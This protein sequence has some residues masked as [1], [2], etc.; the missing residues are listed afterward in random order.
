MGARRT[1]DHDE[2]DRG[3]SLR[4]NFA[5]VVYGVMS[6]MNASQ[7]RILFVVAAALAAPSAG[8][9]A[10]D[11][12]PSQAA[13]DARKIGARD[14]ADCLRTAAD[15]ADKNLSAEV[16][17]SLKNVDARAGVLNAQ[18]SRW[19]RSLNEAEN[20]WVSWR[21][22]ECQDVAPFEAGMNAKGGDPR[23]ACIIDRDAERVADLKA[24][25][26]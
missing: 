19:K 13:C 7:L 10:E 17:A 20:Q 6:P 2:F 26:P 22:V 12:R 4:A 9:L 16:D 23:L 5:F 24:R 14:L 21:D 25:Y 11:I 1:S 3:A 8:A 18:K 15:R